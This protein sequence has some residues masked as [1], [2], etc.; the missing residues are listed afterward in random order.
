MKIWSAGLISGVALGVFLGVI[1]EFL[2]IRVY[3]LLL[4]VDYVPVLKE[5]ALPEIVE[6]GLHLFISVVLAAGVE[7]YANK[8]DIELES[9]F[10]LV[11]LVSLI[12]GLTL[13]PTTLLSN[14]TPP[15]S[16]LYAFLFW[17]LG[18]GLYGLILGLLLSPSMFRRRLPRKYFYFLSVLIIGITLLA[19]WDEYRE[20]NLTEVLDSHQIEK[21]FYTKLPIESDRRLYNREIADEAAILEL[22]SFLSQYKVAKIGDRNFYTEYPDEQFQFQLVYKDDRITMPSLIERD[23]LLN[24]MFQYEITNGPVDYEWL[25]EFLERRG[26]EI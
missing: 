23:V 17:M 22:F 6:F 7:Y 13:Y 26:E 20:K 10:R 1:E 11:F 15:I 3:T 8:K 4:N 21:V 12:I 2:H 19:R 5:F 25:E 16:S 18:H 14:R 9:K 24:D